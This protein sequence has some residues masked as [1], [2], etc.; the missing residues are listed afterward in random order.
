MQAVYAKGHKGDH[1]RLSKACYAKAALTRSSVS[2]VTVPWCARDASVASIL[3][4]RGQDSGAG[5]CCSPVA[6]FYLES[7]QRD[8]NPRTARMLIL[9]NA[10]QGAAAFHHTRSG[11]RRAFDTNVGVGVFSL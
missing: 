2:L 9:G 1:D 5:A 3:V 6:A 10:V 7:L 8:P 11:A 4:V